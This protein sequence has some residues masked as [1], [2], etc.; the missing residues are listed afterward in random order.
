MRAQRRDHAAARGLREVEARGLRRE[1]VGDVA[2]DQRARRG[3]ADED[4]AGP[5]ADRGGG[6]L[7]ERRV[8]LVAD[9]DRVGVGDAAGVAHEPLVGLDGDRAVDALVAL[10]V[11]AA[12]ASCGRRSRA[13]LS[14]PMEL[15]DEVAAVGEDQDA[16]GARGVDEAH[17]GDRLAGAR[18][19]LEPEALVGVG[20]VG[21]A[22]GDV[23][24][25]VA[26]RRRRRPRTPPRRRPRARRPRPRRRSRRSIVD[27]LVVLVLVVVLLVVVV[28]VG[29]GSS[30]ATRPRARRS[31]S[32][33]VLVD[34]EHRGRRSAR[35]G[36]SPSRCARG[37][38][39]DQR[40][41][42]RV[43]LVRVERA[44]RR[45]ASGSSS[46]STRSR[47]SSSE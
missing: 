40:A 45:R 41:R 33:G 36:A 2:G 17:R 19:V 8:G 46:E 3:H 35:R 34:R 43:D 20:V 4:R 25:D 38:Q 28:V 16:A 26:R 18:R 6:L 29:S 9:D 5:L 13:C 14:S 7:A 24:V 10:A 37:Q 27:G 44:C 15:V 42:E 31:S 12:A 30:S 11:R 23:L 1:E 32:A 39:R 21:R 47:P 22:F